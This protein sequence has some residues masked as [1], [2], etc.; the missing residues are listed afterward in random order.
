MTNIRTIAKKSGYS[1]S[2]VSR[3]INQSGYVSDK[4]SK[5]IKR[6]ID[7]MDY[8]PNA[9]ARDLSK[10]Q[11]FTIG[12]VVPHMRHPFFSELTHGIMDLAFAAECNVLFLESQYDE[13]L[14]QKYLEKLHRKAFDALIFISRKLPLTELIKY[15]KYG[16]VVCCE[17]PQ[18]NP[19]AAA[20]TLRESTYQQAFEW[21]KQGGYSKIAIILSRPYGNSATSKIIF[22]SYKKVFGT[23]PDSNL[24]YTDCYNYND[25][26]QSAHL[27]ARDTPDFI[28]GN[29]DDIIAGIY[30]YYLDNN[31][32]LP[33]LM[34]QENQISGSLLKIPTIDHHLKMIGQAACELAITGAIKSVSIE[35]E[36]IIR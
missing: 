24:V 18:D 14:E 10:G 17:N 30:Q 29:S 19:I 7:E 9:I 6:I 34:G 16:P 35:S 36:F 1:A 25:G 27:I 21:V 3:F 12:V 13:K 22:H 8:V 28:F 23:F 32:E 4:A 31:L 33:A 15:Q 2:T 5:E 26:Y 20:Y 11:T